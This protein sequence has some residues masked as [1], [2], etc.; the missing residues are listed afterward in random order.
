MKRLSKDELKKEALR[1]AK[2]HKVDKVFATEDGN[3]FLPADKSLAID[4]NAKNVKKEFED[5][6]VI[7]FKVEAEKKPAK[8]KENTPPP[9]A[10]TEAELI[11]ECKAKAMELSAGRTEPIKTA[12]LK[13]ALKKEG[14]A[15][16]IIDA[17]INEQS[18]H[19]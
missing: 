1:L 5:A 13:K 12:D 18:T 15:K 6:E 11:E 17:V 4:H 19:E 9:P 8:E 2:A 14:F 7:E 3:F 16:E 10:K